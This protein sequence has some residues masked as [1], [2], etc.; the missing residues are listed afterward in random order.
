MIAV[1][2]SKA[3]KLQLDMPVVSIKKVQYHDESWVFSVLLLGGLN[4]CVNREL[5][6]S[7][8][9]LWN[10]GI[11][12]LHFLPKIILFITRIAI[13]ASSPCFIVIY[14]LSKYDFGRSSTSITRDKD[15]N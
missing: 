5:N 11:Q 14:F 3:S 15:S 2:E 4:S 12:N 1:L 10:M 13:F 9:I 7:S 8:F 6:F